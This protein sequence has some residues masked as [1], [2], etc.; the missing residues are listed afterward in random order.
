MQ[1]TSGKSAPIPCVSSRLWGLEWS[2]LLPWSIGD[3]SVVSA[4]FQD[5]LP[6]MK[7]HYARIFGTDTGEER[8]LSSPMTAAKRRFCDES[9]VFLFRSDG[10]TV[11]MFL[12]NPGDWSTYYMRSVAL[13]PDLRGKSVFASFLE[14]LYEPLRESGVERVE[15]ECSP[16]NAPVIRILLRHDFL[17]TSTASSERWG[18]LVRLTKFLSREAEAVFLRQFNYVTPKK[19]EAKS[20][21]TER[22]TL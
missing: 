9:D 22:R 16:A 18:T 15:T 21:T 5:A 11:G 17:V 20:P 3:I 1:T 6:F 12:A 4:P 7:E 14:H 13:L 19:K 8:F 2:R 10:R